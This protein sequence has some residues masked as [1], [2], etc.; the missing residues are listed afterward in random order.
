MDQQELKEKILGILNESRTGVLSTIENDKPHSRYMTF[1]HE[2][3]GLTI[4]TP[5]SKKTEKVDE[6]E[7]NPHVHILL[8]YSGEGL[9]DSYVE[10]AGTSKINDSQDLKQK[11]WSD[12]FKPWFEGPE[13]PDYIF[14]QI[15]PESIRLMN[16]NGNTPAELEL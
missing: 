2:D 9:K 5:T 4:Y 1:I 15:K 11:Y 7:K 8:G 14:L 16:N 6:I 10:I 12:S 13:D 3:D